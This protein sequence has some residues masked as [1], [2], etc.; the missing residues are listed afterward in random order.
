MT[1]L[2]IPTYQVHMMDSMLFFMDTGALILCIGDKVLERI[3]YSVVRKSIPIINSDRY[4]QF[5]GTIIKSQGIVKLLLPTPGNV[6][7]ITI[8]LDEVDG[9]IP[10]QLGLHA[11]DG[12]SLFVDNVSGHLWNSVITKQYSL[13]YDYRWNIKLIRHDENL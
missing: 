11:F 9:N 8:L 3:I 2:S 10:T 7:D 6:Q 13:T 4:F 1:L 12:S 5:G